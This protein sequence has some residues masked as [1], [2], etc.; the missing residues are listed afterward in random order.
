MPGTAERGTRARVVDLLRIAEGIAG[1]AAR[2]LNGLEPE[3]A[4]RA[5]LEAAGDLEAAASALRRLAWPVPAP[6]PGS[7]RRRAEALELAE[8]GW[9][10]QA[11]AERFGVHPSTVRKW[12]RRAAGLLR[13]VT[14]G[15]ADIIGP[16][17]VKAGRAVLVTP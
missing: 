2:S 4:R 11:I 17:N 15:G 8:A 6:D 10:R 5:A 3:Q 14:R 13:S 12:R 9:P 16:D 7:A 1:Y